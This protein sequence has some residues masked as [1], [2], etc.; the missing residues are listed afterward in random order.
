MDK[1]IATA[2]IACVLVLGVGCVGD[3]SEVVY[4][5]N[6]TTVPLLVYGADNTKKDAR[7]VPP[8]E[9]VK[10]QWLVPP[11]WSGARPQPGGPA[12]V[13]AS[14]ESG[15]LVFCHRFTFDE[16]AQMNW[17]IELTRRNDC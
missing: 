7:R 2:V 9:T 17:K 13:Q 6:A 11:V 1:R 5:H 12:K 15:E 8:G 3:T 10:D 16:L 4:Y 14:T